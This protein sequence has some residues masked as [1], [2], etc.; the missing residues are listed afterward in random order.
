[1]EEG[2]N[3]MAMMLV[4]QKGCAPC[5]PIKRR[6]EQ[7]G[8]IM[9]LDGQTDYVAFSK[10]DIISTPSLIVSDDSSYKVYTSPDDI[11]R[12]LDEVEK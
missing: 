1:M 5:V 3:R 9:I 7:I 6:A 12:V 8:G 10:Y 2:R 11:N 4:T